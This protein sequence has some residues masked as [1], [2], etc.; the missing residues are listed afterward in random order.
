M[1]PR[2]VCCRVS[3]RRGVCAD[4]LGAGRFVRPGVLERVAALLK[5]VKKSKYVR[6][7]ASILA[8]I[9]V[10]EAK[11]G[12]RVHHERRSWYTCGRFGLLQ[13]LLR[14]WVSYIFRFFHHFGRVM[15]LKFSNPDHLALYMQNDE[16]FIHF[17]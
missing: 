9:K 3:R 16:V 17:R 6:L 2:V 4:V 10:R 13:S 7:G 11:V 15:L 1:L 5:M 12:N 8:C 14:R